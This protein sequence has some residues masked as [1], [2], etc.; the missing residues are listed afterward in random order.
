MKRTSVAI[1]AKQRRLASSNCSDEYLAGK[2]SRG[3]PSRRK[4]SGDVWIAVLSEWIEPGIAGSMPQT[5]ES[6][7]IFHSHNILVPDSCRNGVAI[8]DVDGTWTS[9]L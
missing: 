8:A 7:P 1:D 6:Y 2:E 3:N 5:L 4:F 9:C